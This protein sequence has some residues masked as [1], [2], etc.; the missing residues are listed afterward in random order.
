MTLPC[1]ND[2]KNLLRHA[3]ESDDVSAAEATIRA[4]PELLNRP[5]SCPAVTL[6]RTVA[7]AERLLALGSDIEAVSK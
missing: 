6:A 5:D 1:P 3:I 4:H 2:A 7:M